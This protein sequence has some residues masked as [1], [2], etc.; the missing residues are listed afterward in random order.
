M[1]T[2]PSSS[3]NPW[4]HAVMGFFA[5][6]ITA[7]V[8]VLWFAFHHPTELISVDYY[9][10]EMR[11]QGRIDSIHRTQALGRQVAVE[12]LDGRLIL[13]LPPDQARRGVAGTIH[14]FRPSDSRLDRRLPLAVND[15]GRQ[16]INLGQLDSGRWKVR[17]EWQVGGETFF[18]E[19]TLD[20]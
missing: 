11:F 14:F 4:P 17:F 15:A 13:S 5:L 2:A 3:Y 7:L 20:I 10:Q 1:K 18:R 12:R 6:L 9:D 16:E 8:S 19:V